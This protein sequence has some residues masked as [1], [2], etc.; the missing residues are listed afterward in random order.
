MKLT[1]TGCLSYQLRSERFDT[2]TRLCWQRVCACACAC[3][4][5]Y[6]ISLI[7]QMFNV[8][9]TQRLYMTNG[10]WNGTK[11][12]NRN[13]NGKLFYSVQPMK[14]PKPNVSTLDNNAMDTKTTAAKTTT[15][16]KTE[17]PP[18]KIIADYSES[19]EK[20]YWQY[21]L[22]ISIS[23]SVFVFNRKSEIKLNRHRFFCFI[24]M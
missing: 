13:R 3:L 20:I 18:N 1:G 10:K 22:P 15:T 5:L 16:T 12:R 6:G 23:I 17:T 24:S 19:N 7:E 14:W 4:N 21:D 8:H 11:A 2:C 9:N